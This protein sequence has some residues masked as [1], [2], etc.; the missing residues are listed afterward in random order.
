MEWCVTTE[1]WC[2]LGGILGTHFEG[3]S[4]YNTQICQK[5]HFRLALTLPLPTGRLV[6]FNDIQA[7]VLEKITTILKN[8]ICCNT[9]ERETNFCDPSL[10]LYSHQKLIRSIMGQAPYFILD[11]W[12]PVEYFLCDPDDKPT[13]QP[14][15]GHGW[16]H[17]L[18]Q[19][20]KTTAKLV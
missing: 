11:S 16:K 3:F 9:K 13:N 1:M 17:N 10:Y 4:L 6:F 15:Y 12:K 19:C 5:V 20:S 8:D 7:L 14:T 2:S 18:V